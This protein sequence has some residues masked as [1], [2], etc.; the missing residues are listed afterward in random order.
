MTVIWLEAGERDVAVHH[1]ERIVVDPYRAGQR[2]LDGIPELAELA[3]REAG[4]CVLLS[5]M[6]REAAGTGLSIASLAREFAV[7]RAHIR[8]ILRKADGLGL[9]IRTPVNGAFQVK[10]DLIDWLRRFFAASFQTHIFAM[11]RALSLH[12]AGRP[13]PNEVRRLA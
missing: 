1:S 9:L 11:D 2:V 8:S 7:S 10:P 6:L 3:E 13:E 5:V 4:L 12:A